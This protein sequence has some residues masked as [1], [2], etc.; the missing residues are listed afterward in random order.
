M[1]EKAARKG[2]FT[3]SPRVDQVRRQQRIEKLDSDE[4]SKK[5]M[6]SLIDHAHAAASHARNDLIAIGEYGI[7]QFIFPDNIKLGTVEGANLIAGVE[8]SAARSATCGRRDF[9]GLRSA[10]AKR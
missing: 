5:R 4:A 10:G 9:V 1:G 8:L 6:L 2:F 7:S 3:E